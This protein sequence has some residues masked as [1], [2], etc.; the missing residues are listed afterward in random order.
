MKAHLLLAAALLASPMAASSRATASR[1]SQPLPFVT[2]A[3]GTQ[4]AWPYGE[5]HLVIT[6]ENL[7][8]RVWRLHAPGAPLPAVDFATED[9]YAVILG[10]KPTTGY[11]VATVG[12]T[13]TGSTVH[14]DIHAIEPGPSCTTLPI[15]TKPFHFV[16]APKTGLLALIF[17]VN[18]TISC[19]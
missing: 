6:N 12:L 13:D 2:L 17:Q 11:T 4:S 5:T 15:Q 14:W 19:L 9:V 1:V 3:Q 16:K 8:K 10:P 18:E 7:W